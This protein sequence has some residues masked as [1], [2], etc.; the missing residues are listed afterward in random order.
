MKL[1]Y[2]LLGAMATTFA[3]ALPYASP[4]EEDYE[5]D[6]EEVEA[7]PAPIPTKHSTTSVATHPA[8]SKSTHSS[9]VVSTVVPS[10]TAPAKHSG[11]RNPFT[12]NGVKA[13]LSGYPD[14]AN[15][16][17]GAMSA[18]SQ[19]IGW[20]SDYTPITPDVG[21]VEGI[22]MASLQLAQQSSLMISFSFGVTEIL[23]SPQLMSRNA[24]PNSTRLSRLLLPR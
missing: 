22:P 10:A 23:V 14:I 21:N 24:L 18:Y 5:D 11:G 4:A 3:A 7:C 2:L 9:T 16:A 19:Y 20:Y 17:P 8:T 1:T 15:T 6:F 12:S 13:G